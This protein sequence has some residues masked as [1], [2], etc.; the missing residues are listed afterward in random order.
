MIIVESSAS[1]FPPIAVRGIGSPAHSTGG[2]APM[3]RAGPEHDR[4]EARPRPRSSPTARGG[5]MNRKLMAVGAVAGGGL[6]AAACARRC[7]DGGCA[8]SRGP[9]FAKRRGE[10][11][12]RLFDELPDEAPPKRMAADIGAIREDT[13]RILQ[14]L[15]PRPGRSTISLAGTE[16]RQGR[17]SRSRHPTAVNPRAEEVAR[18]AATSSEATACHAVAPSDRVTGGEPSA[19]AG[20]RRAGTAGTRASSA[21]RTRR[22]GTPS[23]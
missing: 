19:R 1:S 22:R 15:T 7:R 16:G 12:A 10:R 2:V 13:D 14:L 23:G 8:E 4:V 3:P 6:V 18:V 21:R 11:L 9:H 17:P 20:R 5:T